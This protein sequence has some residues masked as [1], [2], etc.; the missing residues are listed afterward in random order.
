MNDLFVSIKWLDWINNTSFVGRRRYEPVELEVSKFGNVKLGKFM[1]GLGL[2]IPVIFFK[3][4][5]WMRARRQ[6][7]LLLLL[8]TVML[9]H[10]MG[11][12]RKTPSALATSELNLN[13]KQLDF[14]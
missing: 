8:L 12:T 13:G 9:L 5:S 11:E 14:F 7:Y 3:S 1:L 4:S 6:K 10:I 2:V